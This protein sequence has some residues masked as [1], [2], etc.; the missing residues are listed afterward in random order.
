MT[1]NRDL[2]PLDLP[3]GK[4]FTHEAHRFPGKFHPPIVT[5]ILKDHHDHD[6]I[7]DPMSGSGTVAVEGVAN[8]KQVLCTDLDPL[9]CLMTRAKSRPVVAAELEKLRDKIVEKVTPVP[10]GEIS[11]EEAE[12][13]IESNISKT[14]YVAPY[15]TFHWFDPYVVVGYSRLL[16]AADTLLDGRS[17]AM[18]DAINTS[19]AA[20]VRLIS[21][22]DPQ[23]VSG[24]EVTS[25]RE[26]QLQEGI[27]FDVIRSFRTVSN[28][29]IRGYQELNQIE[30]LGESSIYHENGKHFS[31]VVEKSG[32][33]PTLIITSPPYCNAIEYTR[34]HRLESEWLGLWEGDSLSEV[35]D[36]RI[37][38]SRE[39]FGSRTPKQDTFRNLPPAPHEDVR[40]V[41]AIIEDEQ[42]QER[43]ANMLRKYFIDAAKWLDEIYRVLP[44]GGLFCMTIGPSTSYGH[45]IETPRILCELATNKVGFGKEDE[46]RYIYTNNK[47][48]YPTD[49]ETTEY[50]SLLKLRK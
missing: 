12:R 45:T 1:S 41:T 15:N 5:K 16:S 36:S 22:A 4:T 39:F 24:L 47:M 17:D 48:Q 9:S 40:E 32:L 50:E 37:E 19:L 34:R 27:D 23:P 42:E 10:R 13:E 43:K 26:E 31:D 33:Q 29:L 6:V 7:A 44:N 3:E 20:M 38:T 49:G 35:R 46:D 11:K 25:V 28:R 14:P 8:G 2:A 30:E 18:G 21:R